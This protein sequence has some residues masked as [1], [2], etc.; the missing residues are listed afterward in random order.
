MGKRTERNRKKM[1]KRCLSILTVAVLLIAFTWV[2]TGCGGSGSNSGTGS[3]KISLVDAPLNADEVYVD[4]QS[5]QVHN[6]G[7]GWT[8][9]KEY[10]TPLHVNLLDYSKDGNSLLLA[11]SPLSAG[12][13]T[14]VRLMLT[15]AQVVV[16][17]QTYDVDI[18]DVKQTG[19]KCNG[20][21]TVADNSLVALILDFNAGRSF[22]KTGNNTY[23]LHPVMTMSP[24]N[25]AAELTG[26]VEL[27]DAQGAVL[28][29]PDNLIVNV[30][31][32]G[33]VEGDLPISST[34]VDDTN[35]TFRFA[36]LIKGT[37]DIEVLQGDETNGFT[38]L[39][40][41]TGVVVTTP[42]TDIGTITITVGT[43]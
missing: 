38:S 1:F 16:G 8:T 10:P 40:K 39:Y 5:V 26:K 31:R 13:Y 24:V 37:Y 14:M 15:A 28:P 9:V 35:G 21:F 29:T 41:Q 36:V 6:A 7:S 18:N 25:V 43:P 30:Y 23:K 22:V 42:S 20:E 19:V 27:K 32:N 33:H 11:E 34:T 12:H 4:I 3:I 17:G 2:L